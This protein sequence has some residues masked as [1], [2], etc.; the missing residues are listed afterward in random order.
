MKRAA[1]HTR[2]P[3]GRIRPRL[4]RLEPRLLCAI[5]PGQGPLDPAGLPVGTGIVQD[6]APTANTALAANLTLVATDPPP[7]SHIVAPPTAITL[8]FDRP[9][10]PGTLGFDIVLDSVA[11]DGGVTS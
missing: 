3:H 8:T 4:E 6:I 11:D 1:R 7:D 2:K 5:V 9:L 10:D